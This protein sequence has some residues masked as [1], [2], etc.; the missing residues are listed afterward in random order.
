VKKDLVNSRLWK[1]I[2]DFQ[3][4]IIKTKKTVEN[5]NE[6]MKKKEINRKSLGGLKLNRTS[7]QINKKWF[8]QNW[9]KK[10]G[11]MPRCM[12]WQKLLNTTINIPVWNL[13]QILSL[14]LGLQKVR[15]SKFR[16]LKNKTL[17]LSKQSLNDYLSMN[18]SRANL[19]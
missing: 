1:K 9:L 3:A 4:Q 7:Q 18:L 15:P 11:R 19:L 10:W 8:R 6:P 14:P 2:R 12:V 5:T 17:S 13:L 16:L